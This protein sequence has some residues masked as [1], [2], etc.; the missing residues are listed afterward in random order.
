LL[1]YLVLFLFYGKVLRVD[2]LNYG[3]ITYL[4]RNI[5]PCVY[6]PNSIITA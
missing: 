4:I 2:Q 3:K 1:H 6:V 5:F